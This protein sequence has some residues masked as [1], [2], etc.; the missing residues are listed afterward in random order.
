MRNRFTGKERYMYTERGSVQY[1]EHVRDWM[2]FTF[3]C[4]VEE[5]NYNIE[6]AIALTSARLQ[7]RQ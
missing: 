4:T 5:A 1:D 6:A 3:I 7:E 2:W